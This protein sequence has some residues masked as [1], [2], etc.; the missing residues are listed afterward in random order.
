MNLI[1]ANNNFIS[2]DIVKPNGCG[3]YCGCTCS[4]WYLLNTFSRDTNTINTEIDTGESA[5]AG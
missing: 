1:N 2:S 3:C 5:S 4:C